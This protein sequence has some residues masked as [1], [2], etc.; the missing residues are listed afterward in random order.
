M[1]AG[2]SVSLTSFWLIPETPQARLSGRV[3]RTST[4]KPAHI[5][6]RVATFI[7]CRNDI[8]ALSQL[9]SCEVFE[10]SDRV[11]IRHR[12]STKEL[13][14][15]LRMFLTVLQRTNTTLYERAPHEDITTKCTQLRTLSFSQHLQFFEPKARALRFDAPLNL[16]AALRRSTCP[17]PCA[18]HSTG[19]VCG[20]QTS[21]SVP[22]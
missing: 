21:S 18:L 20:T 16:G 3:K 14:L 13:R 6:C 1:R 22:C 17:E 11:L 10:R 5:V 9:F 7:P 8:S 4:L 19:R 15:I 12:F 2:C